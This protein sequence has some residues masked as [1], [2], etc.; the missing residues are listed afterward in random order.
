MSI[1]A[2]IIIEGIT[3]DG[4]KFRPSDWAERMCGALSSYGRDHRI[5][6]SPMMHPTSINGIK[7]ICIDPVMKD[8]HPEM[9]CYIMNF[10]NTNQ[11][12]VI[13][14]TATT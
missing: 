6:Y 5:N 11:L 14:H 9:F 10:A 12:S 3:Q 7:C 13:D 4:R 8:S 2:K 1:S